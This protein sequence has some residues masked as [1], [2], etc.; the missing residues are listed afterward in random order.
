MNDLES[1]VQAVET[2]TDC[3]LCETRTRSVPGE[4]PEHPE[5]LFIGEGPGFHEDQQG[6]PFVGPA[7]KLLEELL[8]TIGMT[9]DEVYITNIVKCRPP[10]NRDPLPAEIQAC[11]KYLD[12]Q[13]RLLD[14]KVIVTLGRFSLGRFLPQETISKA[15]GVPRLWGHRYIFPMYHPA[16]ALHQGNMRHFLEEDIQ[17]LPGLLLQIQ[18]EGSPGEAAEAAPQPEQLKML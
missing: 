7:G 9:R 16:A 3:S 10:G 15:H 1:L 2:C 5:I 14:P 12:Q 11:R 13:I 18:Q 4:G 17:K 8:A 6:R